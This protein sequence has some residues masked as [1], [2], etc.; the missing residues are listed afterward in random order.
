M[1]GSI[2]GKNVIDLVALGADFVALTSD[3]VVHEWNNYA[4]YIHSTSSLESA[5]VN[6][7]YI[8]TRPM[9]P[10]P[11]E[12]TPDFQ[13]EVTQARTTGNYAYMLTHA[14]YKFMNMHLHEMACTI[15]LLV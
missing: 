3:G 1:N 4:P 10:E 2:A 6:L 9:I 15:F 8:L 11:I 14:V 5:A 12:L 13:Q 7:P